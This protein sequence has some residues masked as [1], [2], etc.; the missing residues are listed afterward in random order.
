MEIDVIHEHIAEIL[1]TGGFVKKDDFREHLDDSFFG[2]YFS[3]SPL[4]LYE[5]LMSIEN[6]FCVFFT[7]DEV[8][9]SS[10]LSPNEIAMRI[11]EKLNRSGDRK[12]T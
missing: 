8:R 5:F 12:I 1:S 2:E 9:K 7:S 11:F 6:C 10:F 4:L 3:F